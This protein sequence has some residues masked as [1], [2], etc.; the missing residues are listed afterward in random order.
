LEYFLLHPNGF[1]LFCDH[2][3]L[4]YIFD[5]LTTYPGRS[6]H[7]VSKLPLGPHVV[8]FRYT[9]EFLPGDFSIWAALTTRSGAPEVASIHLAR[10]IRGIFGAPIT[11]SLASEFEWPDVSAVRN[12]GASATTMPPIGFKARESD[13]I[14]SSSSGAAWIP[15]DA[16]DLRLRLCSLAHTVPMAFAVSTA[17]SLLYPHISFGLR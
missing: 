11:S 15:S 7:S 12:A 17:L 3:N 16:V 10:R 2:R 5:P 4:Q 6:L 1:S 9:I 8:I 13:S 14:I